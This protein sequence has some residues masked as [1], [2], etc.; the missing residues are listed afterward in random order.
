MDVIPIGQSKLR[1]SR[2]AYGCMRISGDGS[3]DDRDKGKAAVHA[4]VDAGYSLFDHAD[5][6]GNG[7]CEEL[8]GEVLRESPR[9]RQQILITGKCGVR[10]P[11]GPDDDAPARWDLSNEHIIR[12][13]EGS[14][15]RLGIEQLDLLLLHRPDYLMHTAEVAEAF[16]A[17]KSSG[18]VG[19]FGVSNFS[20]SQV[21]LLQSAIPDPLLINQVEI[22]VHNIS[23]LSDG[24]LDQC[25]RL[26]MT[27]QAWCPIAGVAYPAWGNTFSDE[28]DI[29][30]RQELGRQS[31]IYGV[32]DWIIALAWLLKHPAMI[33]PIIGSTNPSRIAA[34]TAALDVD[35]G[36]ED[37]YRLL[38]ARNGQ[39]VP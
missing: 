27:P 5:I 26:G 11:V 2:L 10:F 18:K 20:T 15:G 30:I 36:R 17:L 31:E 38:E 34:A 9:T 16:S 7:A 8:F 13:V 6:Y 23:A 29:R 14:L 35:Y 37:W 28:D 22:N 24:V 19:H 3:Q 4:A 21:D 33:S 12:S 1:S 32:D 25:L 39:P